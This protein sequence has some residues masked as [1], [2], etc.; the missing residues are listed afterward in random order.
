M[1]SAYFP[2]HTSYFDIPGGRTVTTNAITLPI[3]GMTNKDVFV[4]IQYPSVDFL[5]SLGYKIDRNAMIVKNKP[6]ILVLG[7]T[8]SSIATLFE[9]PWLS[10]V[11]QGC[12]V[13]FRRRVSE[14]KNGTN[15]L[16]EI[17]NVDHSINML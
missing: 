7:I 2:I 17:S 5:K 1:S 8:I 4:C 16:N 15:I 12:R 6:N 11:S 13:Y 10:P 9:K 3:F 14:I